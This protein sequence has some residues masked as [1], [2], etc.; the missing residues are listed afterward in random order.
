M[1]CACA[2][3]PVAL[4]GPAVPIT[5]LFNTGVD[6]FGVPLTDNTP[7]IHY[8]FAVPPPTGTVPLVTTAAG[9]FPIGP[10]L[11]DNTTSAWLTPSFDTTGNVGNYT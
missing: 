10:W 4:A 7:D 9:G 8:T 5:G 1:L 6:A 3:A 11:G 2:G